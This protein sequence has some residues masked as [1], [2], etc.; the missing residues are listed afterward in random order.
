MKLVAKQR[1]EEIFTL[2]YTM[3][4]FIFQKINKLLEGGKK[5]K[6][7]HCSWLEQDAYFWYSDFPSKEK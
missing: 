6:Q 7:K 3:E 1:S 2:I 4:S 5:Q